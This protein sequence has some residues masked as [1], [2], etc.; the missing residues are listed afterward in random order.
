MNLSRTLQ[1]VGSALWIGGQFYGIVTLPAA[2]SAVGRRKDRQ[3][4]LSAGW[5]AWTPWSF[6]ALGATAVGAFLEMRTAPLVCDRRRASLRL[7][8][9]ATGLVSTGLA[10]ALGKAIKRAEEGDYPI[11]RSEAGLPVVYVRPRETL[12]KGMIPVNLLHAI[13]AAGLIGTTP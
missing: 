4:V 2:A 1:E 3:R 11:V 12:R 9:A 8:A 6:A 7:A 10:T 13:S 5:D